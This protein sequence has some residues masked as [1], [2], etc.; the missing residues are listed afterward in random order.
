MGACGVCGGASG[1]H[2]DS[3][4]LGSGLAVSTTS[5]S[6]SSL[7]SA[8]LRERGER[9]F[10]AEQA[11]A[12]GW[13]G[14]AHAR[15]AE[16]LGHARHIQ[17]AIRGGGAVL[18][19]RE[20][21]GCQHMP[22]H[23]LSRQERVLLDGAELRAARR[24]RRRTLD[25]FLASSSRK[26]SKGCATRL[27]MLPRGMSTVNVRCAG[28]RVSAFAE[29]R[30]GSRRRRRS[31]RAA[32]RRVR[33]RGAARP[34]AVLPTAGNSNRRFAIGGA[35]TFKAAL[36]KSATVLAAAWRA[37]RR[38]RCVSERAGR[39]SANAAWSRS[40]A[41]QPHAPTGGPAKQP[42]VQSVSAPSRA[43]VRQ[44]K[45]RVCALGLGER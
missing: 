2:Q 45:R 28:R 9:R 15:D 12:H 22:S 20:E 24:R 37:E 25:G 42:G 33:S 39:P 11:R 44:Q 16:H 31:R 35:R 34:A 14:D 3:R 23:L 4:G 40:F 32:R 1:A 30:S 10:S 36:L 26:G 29:Q 41:K 27:A 6:R 5:T 17:R 13:G 38:A 43:R 19:L 21:R 7:L 8:A 18:R